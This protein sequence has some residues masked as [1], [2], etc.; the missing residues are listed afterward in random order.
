MLRLL[1]GAVKD[2]TVISEGKAEIMQLLAAR[3]DTQQQLR[4]IQD[5]L[6][7]LAIILGEPKVIST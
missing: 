4:N 5:R 3:D 6:Q 1:Q 7:K 2:L